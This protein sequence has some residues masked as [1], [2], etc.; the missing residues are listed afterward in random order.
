M[1]TLNNAII[2][3]ESNINR[4]SLVNCV[5]NYGNKDFIDYRN[6]EKATS[7]EDL[8]VTD[9][10]FITKDTYLPSQAEDNTDN[11]HNINFENLFI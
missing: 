3:N 2:S 6:L 11:F 10:Q 5:L 7:P 4:S 1:I 9:N 8:N